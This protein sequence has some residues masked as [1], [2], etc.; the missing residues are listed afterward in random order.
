MTLRTILTAGVATAL[1]FAASAGRHI[2]YVNPI[3]G[4]NGMGH[5]FPGACAPFG[6]VQL[7]PDTENVPHNINGRYQTDTY[8][9]CAGYQHA[10]STIVGFSHTHLSGTGHSDLGDVMIMPTTGQLHLTPS[11]ADKH[12][13]GY[14]STF[15]RTPRRLRHRRRI[16]SHSAH[17]HPPLYLRNRHRSDPYYSRYGSRHL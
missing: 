17:R 4:T 6:A 14:R 8:A 5:T 12:L 1:S 16:H 15:S 11:T 9:Y 7:S 10:D 13:E 3:I 2:D